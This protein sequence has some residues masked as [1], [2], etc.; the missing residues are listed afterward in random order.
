MLNICRKGFWFL[1]CYFVLNCLRCGG[2][3]AQSFQ[4][5]C[6]ASGVL[7]CVG[8]DSASDISGGVTSVS[9]L[10][11]GDKNSPTIDTTHASSGAGSLMFTIPVNADA[12]SSGAYFTNFSNDLSAQFGPNSD[13]YIQ[14]Q[15]MFS[16]NFLSYTDSGDGWKQWIV[17]TGDQPGPPVTNYYT[18]SDLTIVMENTLYHGLSQMYDGCNSSSTSHSQFDYFYQ[19]YGASDKKLQNGMVSPY[20]LNSQHPNYFPPSGNCFGYFANEWMTFE[21]HVKVGPRGAAGVP[22]GG[23]NDEF[24]NSYVQ[25][26]IARA[27]QAPQLAVNWG[28][29]NLTAGSPAS[30]E[31]FGKVFLLPYN[32]SK[33][34]SNSSAM[35]TW[36][37]SLI[38]S[39]QPITI[40]GYSLPTS[41]AFS[42]IQAGSVTNLTATVTW[43]SDQQ[44]NTQMDYGTTFGSSLLATYASTTTLNSTLVTAHSVSLSG[45]TPATTYHFRVRSSN[46]GGLTSLSS[47]FSFTTASIPVITV[48]PASL[49]TA[50]VGTAYSQTVA[51]SGG[52]GPY[53]FSITAGSLPSGLALNTATGVISGTPATG[54]TATF[55]VLARDSVGNTGSTSVTV[56]VASMVT[57]N[58]SIAISSQSYNSAPF[59]TFVGRFSVNCTVKNT[60]AALSSPIYFIVQQ[61]SKAGT[62]QNPSQPDVLLSADNGSGTVGSLQTLSVTSLATNQT[63]PVT[64]L[65]GLGSRQAF[66]FFVN[67]Y[68]FPQSHGLAGVADT[69]KN[70]L[71]RSNDSNG[72]AVF[73]GRLEV[74]V[75]EDAFARASNPQPPDQMAVITGARAQSRPVIAVDPAVPGRLAVAS[76]DYNLQTVKV[77]T[78]QDGGKTWS[79]TT[80]SQTIGNTTFFGAQDPSLSF[81]ASGQLSV[82]YSLSN[83]HDHAN[84]LVISRSLDLVNFD[85]PLAITLHAS[86]DRIIDSRPV[87]ANKAGMGT[88]V[89]W[90]S[91]SLENFQYSINLV[92]ADDR[93]PFG[94]IVVLSTGQVSSA[95]LALSKNSVYVGWDEWGFNSADPFETGGRL[96]VTSSPH[97]QLRF[98][99][100]QQIAATGIG[101]ARRIPAMPDVGASP[102]LG[103][104]VD[105]SHEDNSGKHETIYAVF[106]DE[107]NGM[108]VFLTRSTDSGA[109]WSPRLTVNNDRTAADQFSPGIDVDSSGNVFIS[110]ED[111]RLSK[112]FQSADIFLAVL[113]NGILLDNVRI[114]SIASDDGKDNPLRNFTA[115]LGDRT[116]IAVTRDRKIVLAW[117]DTRL[118][119]EDIFFSSIDEDARNRTVSPH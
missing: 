46:S 63:T 13:F 7:K 26:W 24:V 62:D 98:G 107:A 39:S 69:G 66:T 32:T 114:T 57:N 79:Q 47:D 28:P 97:R 111:T 45:L 73:L 54:G 108:D 92:H 72:R 88:Y 87:I 52:F 49:A 25:L 60:G 14:W 38:I 100:A 59:Q 58:I 83:L 30:N 53:T 10:L 56:A 75:S 2:I 113:F 81:D 64:F 33:Q 101:A 91:L 117:T 96:M 22:G 1:T 102:D 103:L 55:T 115:D 37:D 70:S 71:G 82:I 20:C 34:A 16:S 119:S 23:A 109:T 77:A 67:L 86:S 44:S 105:P 50:S 78:S 19:P 27:G 51:G 29:Y 61:I 112:T 18:C 68:G 40:N 43:T 94:A 99:A 89:A 41:P 48:S 8:F 95:A 65:L 110:F 84:A 12:G 35:F 11:P 4:T 9:G 90:D 76:N 74:N 93:A 116:A 36:Y 3:Y 17:G 5:L 42:N 15:Q 106:A 6:S 118:G 80:M 104:A 85:P 31:K 21:I